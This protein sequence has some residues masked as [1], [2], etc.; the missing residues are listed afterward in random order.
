MHTG[1]T[2]TRA[3]SIRNFSTWSDSSC[4]YVRIRSGGSQ[5]CFEIILKRGPRRIRLWPESA[6]WQQALPIVLLQASSFSFH[7]GVNKPPSLRAGVLRYF[8]IK[9]MTLS[10]SI[11]ITSLYFH[12]KPLSYY[13]KTKPYKSGTCSMRW[14]ITLN[15]FD[16][17]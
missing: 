16:P 2:T 12:D 15:R 9:S 3:S 7:I 6:R 4:C 13:A 5:I 10:L 1:I 8:R 17:L 14:L 11:R